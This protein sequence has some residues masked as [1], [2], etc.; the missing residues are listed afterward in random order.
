MLILEE[1]IQVCNSIVSDQ[2]YI[3]PLNMHNIIIYVAQWWEKKY[4]LK[5]SLIK[6]TCSWCDLWEILVQAKIATL[7][8]EATKFFFHFFQPFLMYFSFLWRK[9]LEQ[10]PDELKAVY[11]IKYVVDIFVLFEF[12]DHFCKFRDDLNICHHSMIQ[13]GTK[14]FILD[15]E[16]SYE[17]N[18]FVTTAYW[19]PTF[20]G[21]YTH[22]DNFVSSTYKF[23][24]KIYPEL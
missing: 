18:K 7:L 11:Y 21:T 3:S 2:V 19:K 4:L 16:V 17:G 8:I 1:I 13:K 6:H 9:W 15:V 5:C 23:G 14:K 22:F 24:M 20:S 12:Q 10:C